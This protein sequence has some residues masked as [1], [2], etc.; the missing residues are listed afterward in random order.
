MRELVV[1]AFSAPALAEFFPMSPTRTFVFYVSVFHRVAAG[2]I[3]ANTEQLNYLMD[4]ISEVPSSLRVL[5]L[6]RAQPAYSARGA[7][8]R[9]LSAEGLGNRQIAR[10]T[11][12]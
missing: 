1:S 6:G 4:L 9:A 12:P 10:R 3:W 7:G 11:Q 2:Q 5:N 8:C